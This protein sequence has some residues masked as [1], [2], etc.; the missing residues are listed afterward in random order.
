M[1]L[2]RSEVQAFFRKDVAETQA[3]V[4]AANIP[5]QQ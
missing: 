4:K 5:L 3:L 2:S 1:P